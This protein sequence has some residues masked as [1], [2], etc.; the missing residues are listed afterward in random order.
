MIYLTSKG[1]LRDKA[2]REE[3]IFRVVGV[4]PSIGNGLRL[5]PIDH[6]TP[7]GT[8]GTSIIGNA[9]EVSIENVALY[10]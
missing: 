8:G 1:R 5:I 10:L 7:I 3:A 9:S 2:V 6:T 4:M